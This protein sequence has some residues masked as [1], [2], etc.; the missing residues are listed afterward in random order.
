MES[1]VICN[2]DPNFTYHQII[3]NYARKLPGISGSHLDWTYLHRLILAAEN[4]RKLRKNRL[5]N[6]MIATVRREK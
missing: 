1:H 3:T 6:L 5:L 2:G 4:A